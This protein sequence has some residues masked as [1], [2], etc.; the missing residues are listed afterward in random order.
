M[1]FKLRKISFKMRK[2][3]YPYPYPLLYI[4]QH[5]KLPPGFRASDFPLPWLI[6]K[7]LKKTRRKKTLNQ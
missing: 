1:A 7:A 6:E 5:G 2:I 4:K 3:R